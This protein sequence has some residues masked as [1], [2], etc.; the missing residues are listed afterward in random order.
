ML[1]KHYNFK[2]SLSFDNQIIANIK[3]NIATSERMLRQ[4]KSNLANDLSSH[5]IACVVKN[6][7]LI[8]YT[9]SATWATKLRFYSQHLLR[10]TNTQSLP[11]INKIIVKISLENRNYARKKRLPIKPTLKSIETVL[12][13]ADATDGILQE[14][15]IRLFK[16]LKS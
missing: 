16:T 8:I 11:S 9:K 2:K 7:S 1:K 4:I 10:A 14:S 12:S 6:K 15:L 5:I 13:V 3:S